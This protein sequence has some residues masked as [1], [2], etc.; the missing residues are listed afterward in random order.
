MKKSYISSKQRTLF[1]TSTAWSFISDAVIKLQDAR[2]AGKL[3]RKCCDQIWYS[4]IK[5][6]S[7]KAKC[8][9][10]EQSSSFSEQTWKFGQLILPVENSFF[11]EREWRWS[12]S[13]I[14]LLLLPSWSESWETAPALYSGEVGWTATLVALRSDFGKPFRGSFFL[15]YMCII[16]QPLFAHSR[17]C[18]CGCKQVSVDTNV[19]SWPCADPAVSWWCELIGFSRHN[20]ICSLAHWGDFHHFLS[21][22]F[23]PLWPAVFQCVFLPPDLQSCTGKGTSRKSISSTVGLLEMALA[24]RRICFSINT[25]VQHLQDS[26]VMFGDSMVCCRCALAQLGAN[27]SKEPGCCWSQRKLLAMLTAIT[28]TERRAGSCQ[29]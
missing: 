13:I 26:R 27:P 3:K 28:Q 14:H 25:K 16:L 7:N 12:N 4:T 18:P 20:R 15:W 23:S 5:K 19:C 17:H 1:T 9:N 2:F 24:I 29:P 10:C 11:K 21:M 6:W 22:H 8:K